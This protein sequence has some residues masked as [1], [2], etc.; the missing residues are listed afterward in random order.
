MAPF[1]H[2]LLRIEAGLLFM[3]YEAPKL[4]GVLGGVNGQG[5]SEGRPAGA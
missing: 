1:T 2:A 3:E 5:W 4:F